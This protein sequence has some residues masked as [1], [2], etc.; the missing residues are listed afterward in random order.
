MI[1]LSIILGM[2]LGLGVAV[3]VIVAYRQG[4]NDGKRVSEDKPLLEISKKPVKKSKE[5]KEQ[6]EKLRE[7]N[8]YL[9]N[10]IKGDSQ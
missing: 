3:A 8:D 10:L 1:A 9:N 7:Y 4:L 6:E 5:E 2:I